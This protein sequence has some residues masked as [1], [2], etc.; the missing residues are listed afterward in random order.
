[1][2]FSDRAA[3]DWEKEERMVQVCSWRRRNQLKFREPERRVE[4]SLRKPK[5]H[6]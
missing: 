3:L 6:F 2:R 4:T 1:M 5:K